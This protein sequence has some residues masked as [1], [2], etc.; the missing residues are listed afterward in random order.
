MA[1]QLISPN[2]W[3][4]QVWKNGGGITHQL[5][6]SDDNIGM[7]WRVSIA[8]VASDGP[9]SRFEQTDRIIMLLQGNGFC[10][11]GA[12][13]QPV[14]LDQVLLPFA[15]AG[16]TTIECTLI[17]GPV[18]DFNLMTRRADVKASL[19]VLSVTEAL[20]LAL[21][22]ESM[23]YLASGQLHVSFKEQSYQLDAGQSLL[24]T[25]EVGELQIKAGTEPCQLVWI[26]I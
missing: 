21:V 23:L 11:H 20:S 26:C 24:C 17:N 19:Q 3:Q 25:D 8:E 22:Q 10:F 16:E 6:R 9:F 2:Q 7:R 12:E 15:F 5:A 14:V 18:R 4:T 1:L 13:D